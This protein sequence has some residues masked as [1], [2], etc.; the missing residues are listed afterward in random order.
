ME[1]SGIMA[2]PPAQIQGL[3]QVAGMT[4]DNEAARVL[5]CPTCGRTMRLAPVA[6]GIAGRPRLRSFECLNC[7]AVTTVEDEHE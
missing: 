2:V 3:L 6:P 7:D 1:E 4:T 5:A